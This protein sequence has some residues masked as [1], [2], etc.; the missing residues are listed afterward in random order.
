AGLE[1][2]DVAGAAVLVVQLPLLLVRQDGVRL[3]YLLEAL[4]SLRVA[5]VAV[6]VVLGGQL[7][8]GAADLLL[9]RALLDPQ[10]LVVVLVSGHLTSRAGRPQL[11]SSSATTVTRATR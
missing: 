10:G 3:V 4:L 5:R 9:A 6:G 11:A 8:E 2:R 1:R 7:T